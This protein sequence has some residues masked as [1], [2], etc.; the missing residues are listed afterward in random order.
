MD[1]KDYPNP[2]YADESW[3]APLNGQQVAQWDA[4]TK[5]TE[6]YGK[7]RP[8]A[9]Q[10]DNI[11]DYFETGVLVNNNISV[12]KG[13]DGYNVRVS[14]TNSKRTGVIPATEQKRN[15]LNLISSV[16]LSDKVKLNA[17]I[18]YSGEE[19]SG[20]LFEGYGSIG[21]NINQWWQRQLDIDLLKKYYKMPDGR[22]TSWN[23]LSPEN[24]NPLYWD[25]PYTYAYD[26]GGLARSEVLFA[27]AG[28]SWEIVDGLTLNGNYYRS[29]RNKW[30]ESQ[31]P[32]GALSTDDYTTSNLSTK[33]DNMEVILTYNKHFNDDWS[34]S[35]LA[36][37]NQRNNESYYWYQSTVGGYASTYSKLVGCQSGRCDART[38]G[39]V[40]F[41]TG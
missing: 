9:A 3:G 35:A 40:S 34:L 32:S 39:C 27:K 41:C 11:R 12:G 20:N 22:Y 23:I 28:L 10:P 17:N 21:A 37:T 18:N 36:G 29:T 33:E 19:T 1:G 38:R 7:T 2:M 30:N 15:F 25:N 31:N 26:D 16:D 4:F 5:G 6:G 24:P 14:F 8:W 13:G